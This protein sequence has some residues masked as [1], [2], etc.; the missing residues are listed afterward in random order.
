MEITNIL[1]AL[2]TI[3]V[4]VVFV[5]LISKY[6]NRLKDS[7]S[8]KHVISKSGYNTAILWY[9]SY[10]IKLGLYI[11]ISLVAISFL[12]FA[13]QTLSLVAII[14]TLSIIG[15]LVYSLRDLIP[16]AFAGAYLMR[17][18]LIKKGDVIKIKEFK[19]KVQEISLLTTTIKDDKGGIIIIPNK[20][21]T[22][23]IMRKK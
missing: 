22:E 11:V 2:A 1:Y 12:G 16:S 9:I 19:G 15:V 23:K 3:I 10:F 8:F 20:I 17:G 14:M 18:K 13:Q 7:K 6:V 5:Q 21:I 4:G